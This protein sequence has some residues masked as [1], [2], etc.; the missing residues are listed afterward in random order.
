VFRAYNSALPVAEV[1]D[2]ILLGA[3]AVKSLNRQPMLVSAD[4]SSWCVWRWG[5]PVWG[6]KRGAFG[7]LRAREEVKGPVVERGEGEW[8]EVERLRTWFVGT[9][10]GGLED[11]EDAKA[12]TRSRGKDGE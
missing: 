8:R 3:F 5:K 9:V 1:G 11:M 10:R 2:V 4:E 7:E 6:A 12:K